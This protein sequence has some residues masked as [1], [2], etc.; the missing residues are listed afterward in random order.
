MHNE[1]P[2]EQ[3]G[4]SFTAGLVLGTLVGVA[5]MFLFGTKKGQKTMAQLQKR[6]E[7]L[8]PSVQDGLVQTEE[9]LKKSKKPFF[10]AIGEIVE[11]V[12]DHLESQKPKNKT[13]NKTSST[14]K[15]KLY[16]KK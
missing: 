10:Q 13:S 7:K 6:W 12:A 3:E 15:K 2:Q 9:S 8:Q 11:Y 5:G 1:E 16:F 14:T 4:G